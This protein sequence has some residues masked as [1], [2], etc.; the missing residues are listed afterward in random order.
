MK[1]SEMICL[2]A[3]QIELDKD[4]EVRF[5]GNKVEGMPVEG[6]TVY[7]VLSVTNTACWIEIYGE[8]ENRVEESIIKYIKENLR[9]EV[10][11]TQQFGPEE[12]LCVELYLGN[13]K[14]SESVCDLPYNKGE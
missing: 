3:K 8:Q 5:V 10:W 12:K 7:Q 4:R 11:Q 13:D 9:V 6:D 1:A 14:F 2:L